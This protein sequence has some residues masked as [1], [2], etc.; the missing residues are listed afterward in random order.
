MMDLPEELTITLSEDQEEAIDRVHTWW[1]TEQDKQCFSLAG[2]AGTGKTTI[3]YHLLRNFSEKVV[4]GAPTGKAALRLRQKGV[5][6]STIHQ[7]AYRF[8]GTDVDGDPTFDFEGMRSRPTLTI[9]DEASMVNEQIFQ[10]LQGEGYRMLFVGDH[11]QLAPVGGD[12][13]LMRVPDFA[14][15]K[16]H[17]TD[18]EGILSFA[19]ALREGARTPEASGAVQSVFLNPR[20][21]FSIVKEAV[22]EG[23]VVLCWKNTTRHWLNHLALVELG[24]LQREALNVMHVA[25]YLKQLHGQRVRVVCLRT[26]YRQGVYNGQVMD[27][28]LGGLEDE[29][30]TLNGTLCTDTGREVQARFDPLGFFLRERSYAPGQGLLLFDFGYALTAHK[31][32]GSE[33]PHVVVID[34]LHQR[35]DEKPRWRY[36][37]ATRAEKRLTWLHR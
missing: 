9:I 24:L 31:A 28:V 8:T 12:P 29:G 26:N 37:A 27:L 36:T 23:D 20:H 17:R 13:G 15:S 11:G 35:T 4:V 22:L 1:L 34:E 14:L 30:K 2:Y 16:I 3:I 18:D 6:A 7:L 5:Q 25:D 21:E 19:H 33:W 10:D 32:Q